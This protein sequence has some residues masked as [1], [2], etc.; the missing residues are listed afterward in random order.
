MGDLHKAGMIG[1]WADRVADECQAEPLRWAVRQD[2]PAEQEAETPEGMGLLSDA[3][4]RDGRPPQGRD[5]RILGRPGRRRVPGRAAALG[6][7]AG[8]SGR[9][10]GGD[11][12]GHG[13]AER[14]RTA[15]WA[16]STRP[17]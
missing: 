8:R 13:P 9:A 15:R 1:Y 14:R 7:A 3:E 12:G 4:Q 6:G 17:G 11:P 5:D 16:T 10:G 2:D